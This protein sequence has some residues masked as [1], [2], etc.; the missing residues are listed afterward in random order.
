MWHIG[1]DLHRQ[2]IMV[3]AVNDAGEVRPAMRFACATSDE[4]RSY[5][6]Q[7]RPFRAVIEAFFSRTGV[8]MV[9]N[10]SFNRHGQPMVATPRQAAYLLLEG[11]I[12]VLAIEGFIVESPRRLTSGPVLDDAELLAA[13]R[14]APHHGTDRG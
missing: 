10:T 5:F 1:I 8:P 4:V 14:A 7:L 3:A 6:E 9:L 13:M 11:C 12:D 2:S